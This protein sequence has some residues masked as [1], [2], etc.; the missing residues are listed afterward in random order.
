MKLKR[1]KAIG[2][3]I[4]MVVAVY[5]S[6]TQLAFAG[7]NDSVEQSRQD[8]LNDKAQGGQRGQPEQQRQDDFDQ[9][10][11][12][13]TG[14]FDPF[15]EFTERYVEFNRNLWEDT[16]FL[17]AYIP[18][19]MAQFGT[20]DT[21]DV[22]ASYQHQLL[23]L[24][25]AY[26]DTPVGTGYLQYQRIDV[27][28]LTDVTGV[29]FSQA[30]GINF[31][32]SDS[33]ADVNAVK[34]LLWRHDFPEEVFGFSIGHVE[35]SDIDGGG[36]SY[37]C[38]DTASF[39]SAPLATNVARTLPGQ[40]AGVV[41]DWQIV[42]N[43]FLHGG[44][45]DAR[46][47]GKID[48]GNAFRQDEY[49]VAGALSLVNPFEHLGDGFYKF[50]Y[51]YVTPTKQ[52]TPQAAAETEGIQINIEQDV[53]DVGLFGKYVRAFGRKGSIRQ[54]AAAGAVWK[55]PFGY[56]EDWLGL[57]FGWVDPTA[58]NTNDEYVAESFYRLQLTPFVQVSG[59][60][61]LIINPSQNPNDVEG[62]FTLR[63]RGI[64]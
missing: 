45:A 53:G 2:T 5:W 50:S 63:A 59:S 15:P 1:Y 22:T 46:G 43:V 11:W 9:F 27:K 33:V 38:D 20:Q 44:V 21:S 28:Q 52:G 40:G 34:A 36:C 6:S 47:N 32:T 24:W 25:Q 23:F 35:L 4:A 49:A 16:G 42:D 13:A 14:R 60:A 58:A 26:R 61:Q 8:A 64:F 18:T 55:N 30:L 57:G 3:T 39:I 10:G 37:T 51:Y 29:A 48:F 12:P 54:S 31:F 56:E 7:V 19:F 17:Y 41:A 62:V